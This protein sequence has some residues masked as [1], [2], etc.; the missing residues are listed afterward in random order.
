VTQALTV[1]PHPSMRRPA[2]R[3][4]AGAAQAQLTDGRTPGFEPGQ[5]LLTEI[6]RIAVAIDASGSI[7]DARLA[8]FWAEVTGIARRMRAELYLIVFDDR[9]HSC[10]RVDPAQGALA[11]PELPRGG[12]TAFLPVIAQAQKVRAATL[13]VLTDLEGDAGLA[14][15]GLTVIWAVPEAGALTTPY[16][17]LIDL[18]H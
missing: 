4:I 11:L 12:G 16:G 13:V 14:P 7:D 15:R 1:Q 18:S 3:W 8:L 6:P 2:R 17:R 10:A 9:V 5:R